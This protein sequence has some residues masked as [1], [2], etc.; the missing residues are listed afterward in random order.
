MYRVAQSAE[1]TREHLVVDL[2][3]RAF[4]GSAAQLVIQALSSR[5]TS[6]EELVAIRALLDRAEGGKP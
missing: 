3:D 4:G 2:L 6:R 1:S 5:K